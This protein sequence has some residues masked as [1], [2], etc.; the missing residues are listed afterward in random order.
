MIYWGRGIY[1]LPPPCQSQP[2]SIGEDTMNIALNPGRKIIGRLAKGEDLLAA[3]EK[4]T[5][6]HGITLALTLT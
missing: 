1:F 2:F 6:K 3:L 5:Q 4:L